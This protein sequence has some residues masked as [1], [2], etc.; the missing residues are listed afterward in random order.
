MAA[1][2]GGLAGYL[3]LL[4]FLGGHLAAAE[5]VLS[6]V[7]F[8]QRSLD[9]DKGPSEFMF[10][11]DG[12]EI[13]HVDLE[14]KETVWRL[15]QF[16]EFTSFQAEGAQGNIAVLR[17]NLDI[18]MKRS[19]YTPAQNVAPKVTVYPEKPVALG[20]PNMLICLAD[21]F[22]PPVIHLSWW[23]NGQEVADHV[24]ETDFY[25]NTDNSFRK[26]S[27]L[28]FV[29][30]AEDIYYCRVEHWG[31][32]QPLTKEWNTNMPEP[33]PETGA[34]VVCGLGLA[35]GIMGII[36]GTVLI[37]KSRQRNEANF[38]RRPM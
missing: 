11:F 13:F 23:K 19:N 10:D 35:V 37:I 27:Y 20:E 36:A 18:L 7:A 38:R 6:Q 33:L 12:D 16:Q 17:S 30:D 28:P 26:F 2:M 31:L 21:E 29:P 3:W 5:D 34:N 1:G 24:E 22:S 25:P 32:A 14:Q 9:S 4:S 8:V 15:P